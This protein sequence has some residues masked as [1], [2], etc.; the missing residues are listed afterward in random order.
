MHPL[1]LEYKSLVDET[2]NTCSGHCVCGMCRRLTEIEN[3]LTEAL[4]YAAL[5]GDIKAAVQAAEEHC[6]GQ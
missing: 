3:E 4:E 1:I 6:N 5:I 2:S